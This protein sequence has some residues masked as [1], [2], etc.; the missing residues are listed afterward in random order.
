[1]LRYFHNISFKTFATATGSVSLGLLTAS[2]FHDLH[3]DYH[4]R[5]FLVPAAN[6]TVDRKIKTPFQ[7]CL[8]PR[9][10]SQHRIPMRTFSG[11][12]PL[13]ELCGLIKHADARRFSQFT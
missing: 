11:S 5:T 9:L 7:V 3:Q 2:Y 13:P 12:I 6:M 4:K 1:M 8:F 10:P